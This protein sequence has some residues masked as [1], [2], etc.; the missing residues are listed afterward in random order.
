MANPTIMGWDAP[1]SAPLSGCSVNDYGSV[2]CVRIAPVDM[3]GA[4]LGPDAFGVCPRLVYTPIREPDGTGGM[5][6][7]NA[8]TGQLGPFVHDR[9]RTVLSSSFPK[10][11]NSYSIDLGKPF[12]APWAGHFGLEGGS[13][14]EGVVSRQN[15]EIVISTPAI[16]GTLMRASDRIGTEFT[17]HLLRVLG[18]R[19]MSPPT[20]TY[21]N[22]TT[23]PLDVPYGA[24]AVQVPA[25]AIIAF[26]NPPG[27]PINVTL[28]PGAPMP[29]GF[30]SSGT[31]A[32]PAVGALDVPLISFILEIA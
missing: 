13:T 1:A 21:Q 22:I 11:T 2:V 27:A 29:L 10:K 20:L 14:I 18:Q 23:T 8:S 32:L 31:F 25:T 12:V 24:V 16:L 30:F 9:P 17:R 19:P 26:A 6:M 28:Q 5:Q 3:D 7:F 4:A 15:V